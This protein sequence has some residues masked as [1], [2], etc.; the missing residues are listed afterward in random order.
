MSRAQYVKDQHY[1]GT[2]FSP[3]DQQLHGAGG[4]YDG[5]TPKENPRRWCMKAAR[6][7]SRRP[8][9]VVGT[10]ATPAQMTSNSA[11]S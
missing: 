11:T 5:F 8:E 9:N 6:R 7:W 3:G 1:D 10:L 4:D 2:I